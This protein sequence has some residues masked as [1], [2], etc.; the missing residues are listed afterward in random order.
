MSQK[1]AK[2]KVKISDQYTTGFWKRENIGWRVI[3]LFD[4]KLQSLQNQ[5][6]AW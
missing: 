4:C 2:K 1:G 5:E 6:N 3:T